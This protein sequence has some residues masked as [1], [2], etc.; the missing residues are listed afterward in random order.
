MIRPMPT[1][2]RF[3]FSSCFLASPLPSAAADPFLT[4]MTQSLFKLCDLTL[5]DIIHFFAYS[6]LLMKSLHLTV[7]ALDVLEV[8]FASL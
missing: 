1:R 8:V 2:L 5:L 6:L 3:S 7:I 4:P